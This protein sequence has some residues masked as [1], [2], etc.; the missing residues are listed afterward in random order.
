MDETLDAARAGPARAECFHCELPVPPG[1]TLA[2]EHDGQRRPVCCAGC[3][4]VAEAILAAG[5]GDYY[6]LRSAPAPRG[7]ALVP[8]QLRELAIY[9]RPDVE[10]GFLE[11][12]GQDAKEASLILEGTECAACAWLIE[13]RLGTLPGVLEAQV[14]YST[15]RARVRWDPRRQRLSELLAEVRRIGYQAYPYDPRRQDEVLA[16]ERRDRVR[17]LAI[18]GLLGAQVMMLA[19]GLY[20]GDWMGME[21]RYRA[22]LRWASLVLAVPLVGYCAAPFFAAAWR[23]LRN[24]RPGMDVPVALG[25]AIAFAASVHATLTGRGEVYFDSLAMF[26]FLLLLARM[27]EFAVRRR[28]AA[29]IEALTHSAPEMARRIDPA[30]GAEERVPA[31]ELAPGD[32]VRVRP[33]DTVPVDGRI[34][35]GAS[36]LDETL[37][38]GESRPLA[39]GP[40]EAVIAGSVNYDSPLEVL[41]E[42]TGADTTRAHVAA[43]VERAQG[44]RAPLARLADRVAVLFVAAVL[45]LA[46]AVALAWWQIDPQRALAITVAVLVVTCPCA[47]SLATPVA[48][49]VAIDALA[50]NG[51]VATRAAAVERLASVRRVVF[52]KTGTLT[53]GRLRLRA[54]LPAPGVGRERLLALAAALERGSEH[55]V[56]RALREAAGAIPVPASTELRNHPGGGVEARIDGLLHRLGTPR[57]AL[58]PGAG[59][60]E[61]AAEPSDTVVVLADERRL[62]GVLVLGDELRPDAAAL[63][64]TLHRAGLA[65]ALLSGDRP[66]VA[67]AVAERLGIEEATG[68]LRPEDKLERL[69]ALRAAGEPLAMIGDGIND[70][71]VLA[72]ADCSVAM[73]GGAAL[74]QASADLVLA[75]DRLADLGRGLAIARRARAVTRQNLAWALLYNAVALPAAAAGWVPPWAAALGMSLSSLAVL[76]NSLRIR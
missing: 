50:R 68:G 62:L 35:A 61:P 46:A 13:R 73:G 66:E 9:D 64:A 6:R 42:R 38:S 34:L 36:T 11:G 39:R 21:A 2:V 60:S 41:A 1:C 20:L 19:A 25:I 72:A 70:A 16:R 43:L 57:F 5:L 69:R 51:L 40:G 55:P 8:E 12:G 76:G 45:A 53:R 37:L 52:D 10:R 31:A 44:E 67:R 7:E 48:A 30:S 63:V 71:P 47:L 26:V 32:R 75:S 65:T 18:A 33:G 4:A 15:R 59:W 27:I 49:T 54:A 28:N 23:D 58:P 14:N 17:R 24:R 3:Q 56:A 74:A 22:L 29:L